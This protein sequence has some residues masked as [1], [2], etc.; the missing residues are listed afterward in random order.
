ML[1]DGIELA[2]GATILNASVAFGT[3]FPDADK[4]ELFFRTTDSILYVYNGTV[5]DRLSG[6]PNV[7]NKSSATI[8]S[9]ITSL[10]VS[11]ALGYT[12]LS[13]SYS[14]AWS[15]ITGKP[16]TI[17]GYGIVDAVNT[18][19]I[20]SANGVAS[21]DTAG[22][23]P[24][25][26]LMM[27][28]YDIAS[29]IIGKPAASAVVMRFVAVRQFSF[30]ASL[31][32]SLAK[33]AIAATDT[34]IFSLQKN[35]SQFATLTFSASGNTGV[36]TA[37]TQTNFSANDVLTITAPSAQDATFADCEYTLVASLS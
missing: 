25:A 1:M 8:R 21:L 28:P 35:G 26:Q 22:K 4:G 34:T 29:A 18:S 6:I 33:S 17:L 5:W 14:P 23:I 19:L 32:A 36:F 24:A 15:S 37:A 2:A 3:T 30:P 11:T 20:G 27:A 10:N 16:T 7:E 12:P 9:E 31:T 13:N